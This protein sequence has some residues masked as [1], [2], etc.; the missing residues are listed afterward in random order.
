VTTPEG[1]TV[2]LHASWS[3]RQ[4]TADETRVHVVGEGGASL[5]LRTVFGWSPHRGDVPE[6]ALWSTSGDGTVHVILGRQLRDP[7]A[8]YAGQWDAALTAL[9]DPSPHRWETSLH[10][11]QATTRVL[12]ALQLSLIEHAPPQIGGMPR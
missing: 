10:T 11:A 1:H 2:S 9:T 12:E 7:W 5:T 6:P 8:E 3:T 4:V